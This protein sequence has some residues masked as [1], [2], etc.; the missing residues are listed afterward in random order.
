MDQGR[1]G[2]AGWHD[3]QVKQ[4]FGTLRFYCHGV[5]GRTGRIVAAAEWIS[6]A[7]CEECG[8]PGS[9]RPGGFIRTACDAHARR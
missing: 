3:D 1:G 2:P 7:I 8:A 5:D 9:I 4:K 6:G